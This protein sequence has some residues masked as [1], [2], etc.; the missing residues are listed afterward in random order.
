MGP[1]LR[2][3]GL[4]VFGSIFPPQR[5]ALPPTAFRLVWAE[6]CCAARVHPFSGAR[7]HH[8]IYCNYFQYYELKFYK[9]LKSIVD[10]NNLNLF[11]QVS[12]YELV[13]SNKYKDF[14]KIKAKTIDYVITDTNCKIKLC[15]ELD[16][17][18][19]I[20]QDRIERDK[21]IDELFKQLNINLVRI[22]VQNWYDM[23]QVEEKIKESL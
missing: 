19:H 4:F 23:Q 15:I 13:K 20:R 7:R 18:T 11:C 2:E 10:K 3:R 6:R 16:D 5:F 8:I 17:P 9:L 22:S 1:F 14:N 21:F 12:L